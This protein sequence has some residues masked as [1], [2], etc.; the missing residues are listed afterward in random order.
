[1]LASSP[2]LAAAAAA[3]LLSSLATAADTL[4][5]GPPYRLLAQDKGKVAIVDPAGKVEWEIPLRHTAHDI[6]LLPNGNILVPTDNVTVVEMTPD[7][8]VAWKHVS[9]PREGYKGAIE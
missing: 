6:Q 7:K 4:P 3:A 1:M 5:P 2:M 8:K 9:R